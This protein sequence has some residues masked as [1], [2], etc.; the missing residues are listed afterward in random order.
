LFLKNDKLLIFSK[1]LFHEKKIF[2]KN[3]EIIS[4]KLDQPLLYVPQSKSFDEN[5]T[6]SSNSEAMFVVADVSAA[7]YYLMKHIIGTFLPN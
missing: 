2:E 4:N 3:K 6:K 1:S 7:Q 5:K